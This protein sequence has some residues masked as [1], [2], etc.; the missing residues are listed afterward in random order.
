M[1]YIDI[2]RERFQEKSIQDSKTNWEADFWQKINNGWRRLL[3]HHS[4]LFEER[5]G[6]LDL[7]IGSPGDIY[8]WLV[9]AN[10][11]VAKLQEKILVLRTLINARHVVFYTITRIRYTPTRDL[12]LFRYREQ[13]FCLFVWTQFAETEITT[14]FLFS[15]HFS[16]LTKQI[17]T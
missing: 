14:R 17:A 10:S 16:I 6:R 13:M 3:F 7:K 11:L 5:E 4:T 2:I 9:K 12:F 15:L 1:A 8:L